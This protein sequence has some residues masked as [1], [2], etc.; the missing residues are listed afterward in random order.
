MN[1]NDLFSS[2]I[3]E[4][5]NNDELFDEKIHKPMENRFLFRDVN[6]VY[7]YMSLNS[8]TFDNSIM[9]K[10]II[11]STIYINL[12]KNEEISSVIA[13]IDEEKEKILKKIFNM[14]TIKDIDSF[15]KYYKIMKSVIFESNNFSLEEQ[16]KNF[17]DNDNV[18]ELN[19]VCV[20]TPSQTIA[21]Y[22]GI[23]NN[24]EYSYHDDNFNDIISSVYG[25]TF[26]YNY[27]S[28]DIKIRFINTSYYNQQFR[29]MTLEIPFIIN[30]SQL[31]A[32]SNLND[33]LKKI[34]DM[35]I[36]IDIELSIIK[37]DGLEYFNGRF[38]NLDKILPNLVIND[39]LNY[40]YVEEFF[41]GQNNYES[42]FIKKNTPKSIIKN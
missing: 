1:I 9:R 22:N 7:S 34:L 15:D 3:L 17:Y 14:K 16:Y 41:V 29:G 8:I 42:S 27:S 12:F 28:Q 18:H 19:G 23:S 33:D 40:Q 39:Y 6:N 30:S 38:N 5:L 31:V 32:L 25:R 26:E 11:I 13:P 21:R 10:I 35:G 2:D 36:D 24:E 20:V 4:V 37:E